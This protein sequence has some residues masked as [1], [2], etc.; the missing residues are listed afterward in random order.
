MIPFTNYEVTQVHVPDL[1]LQL[2]PDYRQG[3]AMRAAIHQWCAADSVS[4]ELA[5]N[6]VLIASELF[7]NAV[8]ATTDGSLIRASVE[9][10][11]AG[12]LIT[13]ANCGPGFDPSLLAVP[14]PEVAGGR[15]IAISKAIG[16]VS[17]SQ[18]QSTTI[19]TVAL[20]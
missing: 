11:D 1:H 14:S 16:K 17:V 13:V 2:S 5:D 7:T 20:Y 9:R 12:V 6:I 18:E 8:K 10:N 15:G 4:E 3:A 19:V